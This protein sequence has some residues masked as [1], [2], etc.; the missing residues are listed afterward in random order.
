[1]HLEQG[2]ATGDVGITLYLVHETGSG[3]K[4]DSFWASLNATLS[5]THSSFPSDFHRCDSRLHLDNF[6]P[7]MFE[8]DSF[9]LCLCRDTR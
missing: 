5:L 8:L 3:R 9:L 7:Q 4:K 2:S 6:L 1:M